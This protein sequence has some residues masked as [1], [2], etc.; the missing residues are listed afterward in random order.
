MTLFNVGCMACCEIFSNLNL[1]AYAK[2]Q[3]MYNLMF[4]LA[5]YAGVIYFLI[6]CF[7]HG[8]LMWTTAMWEGAIVILSAVFAYFYL[9]ERF[10][11]S[12]Q[13]FGI[14]LGIVAMLMVHYGP[15]IHGVVEKYRS[16]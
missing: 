3:Q 9:D 7:K 14:L 4:G 5:G 6:E 10:T 8:N 12:I 15:E 13:Y 16:T 1:Q 2:D 11:H